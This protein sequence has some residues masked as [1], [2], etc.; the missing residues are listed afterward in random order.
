MENKMTNKDKPAP[1]RG[2]RAMWIASA[3]ILLLIVGG[4]ALGMLRHSDPNTDIW[5]RQITEKK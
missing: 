3:A 4:M 2:V 5:G 1:E